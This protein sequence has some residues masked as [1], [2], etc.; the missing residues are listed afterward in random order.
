MISQRSK[1]V[2]VSG[3]FVNMYCSTFYYTLKGLVFLHL[4]KCKGVPSS[5]TTNIWMTLPCWT[6]IIGTVNF[7]YLHFR[8]S[9]P[10]L[11]VIWV[12]L[13]HLSILDM[14]HYWVWWSFCTDTRVVVLNIIATNLGM[15]VLFALTILV[16]INIVN[17]FCEHT[18]SQMFSLNQPLLILSCITGFDKFS[19]LCKFDKRRPNFKVTL[20]ELICIRHWD[21]SS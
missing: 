12:D 17:D 20:N 7:L 11:L 10:L 9:T 5:M 3:Q 13:L 6:W 14:Y 15:G 21:L 19:Y 1:W 18:I 4:Y 8:E 2:N 16:I